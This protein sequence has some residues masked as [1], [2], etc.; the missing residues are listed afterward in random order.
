MQELSQSL[1]EAQGAVGA[2]KARKEI[3]A[4]QEST[5]A[6]HLTNTLQLKSDIGKAILFE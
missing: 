6:T 2:L 1:D 3:I 4:E 5:T